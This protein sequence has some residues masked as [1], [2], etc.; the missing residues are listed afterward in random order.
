MD[1]CRRSSVT[2]N[3]FTSVTCCCSLI[4]VCASVLL[5]LESVDT[6]SFN[7]AYNREYMH[8]SKN[9]IIYFLV[10]KKP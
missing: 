9:K 10:I 1:W 3:A 5:V 6:V 7:F 8:I 2:S 4:S